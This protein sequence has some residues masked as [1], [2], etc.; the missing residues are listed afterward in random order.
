MSRSSS[1]TAN[2]PFVSR[3]AFDAL[4]VDDGEDSGS[5]Q[6]EE[7]IPQTEVTRFV[8]I[9]LCNLIPT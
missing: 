4:T 1:A 8:S 6:Q 3:S 2:T 9:D 5:E 7:E